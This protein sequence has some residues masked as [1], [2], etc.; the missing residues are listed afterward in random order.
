MTRLQEW[1]KI[2]GAATGVVV[3]APYV[4]R[5]PSGGAVDA[6]ALLRH[7]GGREG[8]IIV[9]SFD[10]VK[11]HMEELLAAGYGYSVLSEPAPGEPLDLEE[12]KRMFRDWD[13]N[14]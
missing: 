12:M 7:V 13:W 3:E 1:L 9:T 11:H 6:V 10:Q 14:G 8:M 4:F 2:A 5:L